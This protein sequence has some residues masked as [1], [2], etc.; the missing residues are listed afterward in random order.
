MP[1]DSRRPFRLALLLLLLPSVPIAAGGAA[2][3]PDQSEESWI[4]QSVV[5]DIVRLAGSKPRPATAAAGNTE[6][7]V[8]MPARYGGFAATVLGTRNRRAG[9]TDYDVRTPL[10]TPTAATLLAESNRLSAILAADRRSAEAHESAALLAGTLALLETPDVF[11]DARP[12]LARM[13]AHLAA[14]E[15]LRGGLPVTLDGAFAQVV[16]TTLIGHQRDAVRRLDTL[17]LPLMTEADRAWDRALRLRNTGDWTRE[18]D[19]SRAPLLERL[20]RARAI[21][22]RVGNQAMEA[23]L[24]DLV[25]EDAIEW[26]RLAVSGRLSVGA[27]RMLSEAAV[28]AELEATGALWKALHPGQPSPT[29]LPAALGAAGND[30]L[31][32][33]SRT[34][35]YTVL[36]WGLLSGFAERRLAAAVAAHGQLLSDLVLPERQAALTRDAKQRYATLALYPVLLR[37]VATTQDDYAEAASLGRTLAATRPGV[38][39]AGMWRLLATKPAYATSTAPFPLPASWFVAA[40]PAGTAFDLY[41][42]AMR[43]GTKGVATAQLAEWAE[44][45]PYDRWLQ[46]SHQWRRAGG[47]PTFNAA[48]AAFLPMLGYD[49]S[50]LRTLANDARAASADRLAT[51]R[52]MCEVTPFGCQDLAPYL[53]REGLDNEAA[54]AYERWMTATPDAVSV[55][56]ASK[57]IVRYYRRSGQLARAGARAREAGDAH[58]NTGLQVY[59]H[60][61][62]AQGDEAGAEAAYRTIQDRY[63]RS[64]PLG[65]F[66]V[67]RGLRRRDPAMQE[68][69]WALLRPVFPHGGE[70]LAWNELTGPPADGIVFDT[71]GRRA[72]AL[73]LKRGDVIVGVDEWRVRTAAQ[74]DV[75]ADL[76]HDEA[77]T[78]TVWRDGRYEPIHAMVRERWLGM[79]LDSYEPTRSG[80]R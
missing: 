21:R 75:L 7:H 18:D 12:A 40:V 15:A 71:F 13:T 72:A 80:S 26:T 66:M 47:A 70:R 23:A 62:D 10:T 61:L 17:A 79:A 65:T 45:R 74:Y 73:G 53:V 49:L 33:G 27:G 48:R 32:R 16:L 67:R 78:F 4:A 6:A 46:W 5:A 54:A 11:E 19:A 39:T 58:S 69:G 55:A 20:E 42:R 24:E 41:E 56:N 77:M 51:F 37:V 57:W 1:V 28:A 34:S 22:A 60:F 38:L 29:D 68:Q 76:R 30:H 31:S 2:G 44:A 9:G 59:G 63:G 36:D 8:W 35:R 50:A 3:P 43:P 64:E 25:R 14:A 52:E